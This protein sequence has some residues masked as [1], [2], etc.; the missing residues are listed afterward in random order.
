MKRQEVH[1]NDS[2]KR[3]FFQELQVLSRYRLQVSADEPKV[4]DKMVRS[5]FY[6]P[7]LWTS[8]LLSSTAP[9]FYMKEVYWRRTNTLTSKSSS[10]RSS[11]SSSLLSSFSL[12]IYNEEQVQ[13]SYWPLIQQQCTQRNDVPPNMPTDLFVLFNNSSMSLLVLFSLFNSLPIHFFDLKKYKSVL[14]C[15]VWSVCS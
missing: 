2:A 4:D 9:H 6:L 3:Y 7:Q 5:D 13:D 14:V 8:S 10:R 15:R 1:E 11:F 12:Q